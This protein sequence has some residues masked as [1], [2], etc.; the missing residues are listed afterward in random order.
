[1]ANKCPNRG[2][3]FNKTGIPTATTSSVTV[4]KPAPPIRRSSSISSQDAQEL[5]SRMSTFRTNE[6]EEVQFSLSFG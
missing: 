2:S 1:M 4:P 5:A 6:D 3:V